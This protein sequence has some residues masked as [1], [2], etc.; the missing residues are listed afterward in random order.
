[1]KIILDKRL[2]AGFSF[3]AVPVIEGG[4]VVGTVPNTKQRH[5]I[6]Y[7]D[8]GDA[9]TGFGIR[10]SQSV[11]TYILQVRQNAKVTTV[12][13]GRHPDLLIGKDTNP[14]RNARLAASE[15]SARL[16]R[17]EDINAQRRQVQHAAKV[18]TTTLR[19]LF[20]G[21][22]AAYESNVKRAP[23]ENTLHA[24]RSA[25]KRLGDKILDKPADA[26]TW[27]DM[28]DFFKQKAGVE[29]HQTAAE[30]TV[31]WVSAVYNHENDQRALAALSAGAEPTVLR[32]PAYIFA[33]TGALRNDT[34]LARD[35]E[36]KGVRKP[37]S[38]NSE[39]FTKWL[40]YV[41]P[42]RGRTASA[43]AADYLLVTMIMGCR[44]EETATLYWSDRIP[45][46]LKEP[47]KFIDLAA[48][49]M[50][51]GTTKN[52]YVHRLPLPSYVFTLLQERRAKVGDSPF[53][54]PAV[55]RS[56]MRKIAHYSDPSAF[57]T[58]VKQSTG[59]LFAMHDLRRTFGNIVNNM[60]IPSLLVKQLMNH[61]DGGSTDGYTQ[62]SMEQL[63]V[64]MERIESK[65]LSYAT[66]SPKGAVEAE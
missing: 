39:S 21:F 51:L 62:Q 46:G 24:I 30:Q 12:K 28:Q 8:H 43:T 66:N 64:Y 16:R 2:V 44:R 52:R 33:K 29:K 15:L 65:M 22:I 42:A 10:V 17:G 9:P 25:M 59:V 55:S 35:Y 48:K 27:L 63:A 4:K 6:V 40:D 5:Y 38:A 36:N 49:M 50:V 53:V 31:R 45:K 14:D 3:D 7:D 19:G 13:V 37:L 34:E 56:K 20:D 47:A 57:M 11:K 41:I 1:M 18:V 61:K 60:A 26:V 32:N 58:S 54:F 23:R